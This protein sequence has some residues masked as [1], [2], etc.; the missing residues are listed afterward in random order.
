MPMRATGDEERHTQN[1]LR[2]PAT[3]NQ[4][5]ELG[6]ASPMLLKRNCSNMKLCRIR[7]KP[8]I[9]HFWADFGVT[10]VVCGALFV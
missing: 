10:H 9:R 3:R 5:F 4:V 8:E 7:A 2:R 6:F 1:L